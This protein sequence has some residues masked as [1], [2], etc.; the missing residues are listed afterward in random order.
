[1]FTGKLL[2]NRVNQEKSGGSRSDHE[3]EQ[4]E[5]KEGRLLA[6]FRCWLGNSE[7]FDEHIDDEIENAHEVLWP[8]LTAAHR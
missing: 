1:M 8:Q 7:C 4:R 6:R 2:H 3:Q 5:D